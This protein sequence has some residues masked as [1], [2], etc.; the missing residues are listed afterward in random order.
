[1]GQDVV[2]DTVSRYVYI[3]K[4]GTCDPHWLQ[5]LDADAHDLRDT[6]TARE[7]Y[8]LEARRYGVRRNRARVWVRMPEVVSV[9]GLADVVDD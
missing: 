8:V 6:Q 5:L 1:M 7:L 2:V 4:L 3:G 9:S